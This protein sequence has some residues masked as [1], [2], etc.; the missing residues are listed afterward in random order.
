[1]LLSVNFRYNHS[2]NNSCKNSGDDTDESCLQDRESENR[3]K[4]EEGGR[5]GV[6]KQG[7]SSLIVKEGPISSVQGK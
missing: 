1:M 4:D 3:G 5:G 6:T 7:G 2:M